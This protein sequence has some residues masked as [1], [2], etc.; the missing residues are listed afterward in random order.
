MRS[1]TGC[2]TLNTLIRE[3]RLNISN[4]RKDYTI[5]HVFVASFNG[6]KPKKFTI[7]CTKTF[8]KFYHDD[9]QN[10][11]AMTRIKEISFAKQN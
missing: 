10:V 11:N 1:V 9:L 4:A 5:G 6:A 2:L 3:R 8:L 7:N